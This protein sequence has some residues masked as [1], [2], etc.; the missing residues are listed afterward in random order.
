MNRQWALQVS[1]LTVTYN[2]V[3]V[4]WQV[5]A[6]IKEG[7]LLAIVGPNGAGKT[8]LLKSLLGLI[9]PAAGVISFFGSSYDKQRHRIA[10][11]PQRASVDWD[12]PINALEVVLMGR[13]GQMGLMRRPK[14]A[15]F[16]A[17]YYALEQV[18]M[19]ALADRHIS[20]LSG[21]QQQRIFL[22]RALVQQADIYLMDE[23][24]TGIDIITEQAI[25]SLLSHLRAQGKTIIA[26]HH[27]LQTVQD[28]FDW[29]WVLNI[30][31]IACGPVPEV[32]LK[33]HITMA[34]GKP[35]WCIKYQQGGT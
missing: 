18:D 26:V 10:Y 16:D 24:F 6:N 14:A 35:N 12:F 21:G 3:P 32:L 23:P 11:V 20:E 30:R 15:D 8:T 27:D 25:I 28:Y 1:N 9:K 7:V 2:N 13:Y 33:E 29:L 19:L 17:A 31:S 22:A 5:S 34:Y 4:L